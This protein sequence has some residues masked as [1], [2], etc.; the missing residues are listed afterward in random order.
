[1][2]E[3]GNLG[4]TGPPKLAD[5]AKILKIAGLLWLRFQ[6]NL[7][8]DLEKCR[9]IVNFDRAGFD[10]AILTELQVAFPIL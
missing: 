9:S 1:M 4:V 10:L 3:T 8:G 5:I 2:I 7:D 6:R